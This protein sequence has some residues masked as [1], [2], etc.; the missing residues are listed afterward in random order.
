MSQPATGCDVCATCR[1]SASCLIYFADHARPMPSAAPGRLRSSDLSQL[2]NREWNWVQDGSFHSCPTVLGQYTANR[3]P[4]LLLLA[5]LSAWN[6]TPVNGQRKPVSRMPHWAA[7][8]S[9][10]PLPGSAG[11]A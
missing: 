10:H 5:Q 6:I 9:D 11:S 3:L 8:H 1:T 7:R 4:L 2:S